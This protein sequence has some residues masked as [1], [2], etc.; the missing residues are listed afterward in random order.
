MKEFTK[1]KTR[2]GRDLQ[3]ILAFMN[4][5]DVTEDLSYFFRGAIHH[6]IGLFDVFLIV[7]DCGYNVCKNKIKWTLVLSK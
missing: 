7:E 6:L 2:T 4:C 3:F 1:Y 5:I